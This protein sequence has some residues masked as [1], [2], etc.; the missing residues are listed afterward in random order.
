MSIRTNSQAHKSN[1]AHV[2]DL[3]SPKYKGNINNKAG[4][5]VKFG[6]C[7]RTLEL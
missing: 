5:V 2:F 7:V 4:I 6:D 1:K 3:N